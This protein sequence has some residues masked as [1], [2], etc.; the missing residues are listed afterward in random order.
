LK[1]WYLYQRGIIK[2]EDIMDDFKEEL[3]SILMILAIY[4]ITYQIRKLFYR[5]F[6]AGFKFNNAS[7]NKK[8]QWKKASKAFG[9]RVKNLKK[10]S[11]E[12]IKSTFRKL[13]KKT[14]PDLGGNEEEFKNLYEAYRFVYVV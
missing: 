2:K 3:S 9:I 1:K 12:E 10:M 4:V 5:T 14:H 6:K 7:I 8:E 13:A 11:K